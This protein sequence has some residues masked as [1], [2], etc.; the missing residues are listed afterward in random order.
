MDIFPSLDRKEDDRIITLVRF[1]TRVQSGAHGKGKEVGVQIV[2]DTLS[3]QR[4]LRWVE[5]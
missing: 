4:S 3:S 2:A 5:R 1:V